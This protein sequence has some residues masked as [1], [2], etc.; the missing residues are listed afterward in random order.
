MRKNGFVLVKTYMQEW[1]AD[2]GGGERE[3][4][5]LEYDLYVDP[6]RAE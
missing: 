1:P 2:K 3:V 6:A 5:R 4:S